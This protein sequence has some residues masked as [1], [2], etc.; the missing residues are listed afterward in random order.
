MAASS[1][2]VLPCNN[3]AKGGLLKPNL[4]FAQEIQAQADRFVLVYD[5]FP[6]YVNDH[7]FIQDSAGVMH[8]FHITGKAGLGCYAVGNEVT[9]GHA[10]STDLRN[11]NLAPD[12]L[13]TDP[14]SSF[15]TDHIIAPFVIEK[16]GLYYLFYAGNNVTI[17]FESMCL[18]TSNDLVHWQKFAYNPVFRPSKYWAEYEPGSGVWGCCRDPHIIR[19]P[20]YGFILYYVAWIKNTGGCLVSFGAAVSQNLV[21][22]Q[23]AGPVH[24]RQRALDQS[25]TSMESPCVVQ[26]DGL[27]YLFYKHQDETRLVVSDDPLHFTD[28][29]DLW[30]S[31]AHA[32]EVFEFN[33]Q[34]YLSSCSREIVDTGHH[35]SDRTKGLYLARL[36]WSRTLPVVLPL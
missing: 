8:L 2:F 32:A 1:R 11:W 21:S 27:F 35:Y 16:E 7:C 22:W 14:S 23:D 29:E 6:N 13:E 25:T 34:W 31:P 36:D 20:V 15:E 12:L 3:D 33:G 18:A 10:T 17:Q 26:K 19:H 30:F 24:V 4:K 5:N 9:I 28:K